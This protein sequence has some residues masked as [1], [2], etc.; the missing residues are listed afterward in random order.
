MKTFPIP[1][2]SVINGNDRRISVRGEDRQ[3]TR[4]KKRRVWLS[5]TN[6]N[7]FIVIAVQTL[8]LF[9]FVGL[10]VWQYEKKLHVSTE[11]STNEANGEAVQFQV[12]G[13][14]CSGSGTGVS[15]TDSVPDTTLASFDASC[16]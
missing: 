12:P 14:S 6:A 2:R 8:V 9:T 3:R 10:F 4:S 5:H 16:T 1:K 15:I 11:K 7:Y 13:A